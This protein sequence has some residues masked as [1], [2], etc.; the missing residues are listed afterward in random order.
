MSNNLRLPSIP[1]SQPSTM[2][3]VFRNGQMN[4]A[5][6]IG[7]LEQ[8]ITKAYGNINSSINSKQGEFNQALLKTLDQSISKSSDKMDMFFTSSFGKIYALNSILMAQSLQKNGMVAAQ[9]DLEGYRNYDKLI[10]NQQRAFNDINVSLKRIIEKITLKSDDPANTEKEMMQINN[11]SKAQGVRYQDVST[12]LKVTARHNVDKEVALNSFEN[13]KKDLFDN[14]KKGSFANI[15]LIKSLTANNKELLNELQG[16]SDISKFI[17]ILIENL[18]KAK[19]N[20]KD[21]IKKLHEYVRDPDVEAALTDEAIH[22]P[23]KEKDE[24]KKQQNVLYNIQKNARIEEKANERMIKRGYY[25]H[26]A[27]VEDDEHTKKV[28]ARTDLYTGNIDKDNQEKIRKYRDEYTTESQDALG[29]EAIKQ[30]NQEK[31]QGSFD[32]AL[33]KTSDG[34]QLVPLVFYAYQQAKQYLIANQAQRNAFNAPDYFDT[35]DEAV[36][37]RRL[38]LLHSQKKTLQKRYENS[39]NEQ[40]KEKILDRIHRI[41]TQLKALEGNIQSKN[42]LINLK[43]LSLYLPKIASVDGLPNNNSQL[44]ILTRQSSSLSS[45]IIKKTK[46]LLD[47]NLNPLQHMQRNRDISNMHIGL[48]P[49]SKQGNT[50]T[51]HNHNKFSM[52]F[53]KGDYDPNNFMWS[54]RKFR[55]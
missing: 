22:D 3:I 8:A 42:H 53:N 1:H 13:I 44:P 16:A 12:Y 27:E 43:S 15:P 28:G 18:S 46:E 40:K 55:L 47:I 33:S 54:C 21:A 9:K 11:F 34:I 39:D 49:S 2:E 14:R 35:S 5:T 7:R 48:R 25:S 37:K 50:I 30:S 36:N 29:N 10:E 38:K 4:L 26:A 32:D 19:T 24:K 41:D 52:T 23:E 45:L 20:N 31:P 51:V 6:A 17:T